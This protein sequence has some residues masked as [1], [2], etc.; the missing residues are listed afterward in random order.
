[1]APQNS[2]HKAKEFA[3]FAVYTLLQNVSDKFLMIPTDESTICVTYIY[4]IWVLADDP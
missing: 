1:M 4:S 2:L 3:E